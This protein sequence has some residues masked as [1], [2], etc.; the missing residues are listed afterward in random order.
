MDVLSRN[1]PP[2]YNQCYCHETVDPT[3][4][5][6]YCH[7]T[8]HSTSYIGYH[9]ADNVCTNNNN[10]YILLLS[11]NRLLHET[12]RTRSWKRVSC[13]RTQETK[14]LMNLKSKPK[15]KL[16]SVKQNKN[17]PL[18]VERNVLSAALRQRIRR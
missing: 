6:C 1:R 13:H 4:A 7:K 5:T 3:R 11:Q 16:Q 15:K 17:K 9:V 14:H 10:V 2:Y 18:E 8:R 12:M